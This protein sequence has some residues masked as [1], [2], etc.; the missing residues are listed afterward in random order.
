MLVGISG[1]E[2]KNVG[3]LSTATLV[4]AGATGLGLPISPGDAQGI[5]SLISSIFPGHSNWYMMDEA[6]RS[7][8]YNKAA[9]YIV[10]FY[11]TPSFNT[12][13]SKGAGFNGDLAVKERQSWLPI[14]YN[15]TKRNDIL[16]ILQDAVKKGLLP[17][18]VLPSTNYFGSSNTPVINPATGQPVQA[19]TNMFVTLGL[20]GA[21]LFL[22]FKKK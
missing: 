16:A 5:I 9:N 2:Q 21:A 15:A 10:A 18:S 4:S 3:A 20:V 14:I 13:P 6:Y 11:T 12:D 22:L 7:G 19:G 8:D 17:S 1:T